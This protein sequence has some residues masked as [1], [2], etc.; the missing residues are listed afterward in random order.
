MII[1]KKAEISEAI[2]EQI[3]IPFSQKTFVEDPNFYVEKLAQNLEENN[4]ENN[5]N[6]HISSDEEQIMYDEKISELDI[7][8]PLEE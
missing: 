2:A 3:N 4:V 7:E 1:L 6:I 8:K 5:L